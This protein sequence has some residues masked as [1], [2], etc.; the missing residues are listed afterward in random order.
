MKYNFADIE[1]KW[2]QSWEEQGV[3][4]TSENSNKPKKYILGMFPY[5]SGDGLHTGHVKL[6]TA[7]DI[8]S[9][10]YRARGYN[11]L[12]PMGWD[13]FGLPAENYA[14]KTG[15]Q[16]KITT[17]KNI[18]NF[19]GEMKRIGL[20]YDWKR[21]INTTDPEYYRWTQWI[22]LQLFHKGLAYE[23]EVAINWC[24]KDKT[25]LANEEVVNGL[26]ERC[27]TKVE[28]KVIRQWMLRITDYADRLLADLEQLEW[29]S[30]IIDMQRNWIGRSEGALITFAVDGSDLEL[31]TFTTRPDTLFGV[32]A[33][34]V[35]P[36]YDDLDKLTSSEQKES[37][38][39]YVQQ[40]S[41]IS[42]IERMNAEKPKTGVFTGSYAIHPLTGA[43]VPIWTADYVLSGY[44]T[45][46]V[47]VVPAHDERDRQFAETYELPILMVINEQ[48]QL[49]N[50][51]GYDGLT[52]DEAK[53]RIVGS[54]ANKGLAEEKVQ[55]KLRDWV[56]SRQRYWGEPIPLVHCKN[57]GVVPL[58]EEQLPLKLPEVEKYEPTG[59]GESPLAKMD[60]WVNTTCPTCNGPAKRET[61]TM[62]QWAGS[63]WYYLRF[64]DPHNKNAVISRERDSYWNP[65]D[66]YLGGAEHAVL[67]LLYAR[68]WH[69]VLFD[70]SLVERA[71]PFMKL[72]SIG[73]VLAADGKKMSKSLGN[74]I[75]PDEVIEDFGADTL[76]LYEAFMGPFENTTAWNPTGING[77]HRFLHRAWNI[78]VEQPNQPTDVEKANQELAVLADKASADIENLKLNTPIAAMMKFLNEVEAIGLSKSQKESFLIILS[79]FAPHFAEE[80]WH[81]IGN[82]DSV[83]I[84][85]WPQIATTNQQVSE[86]K[87]AVQV[88]GKVRGT[89]ESSEQA[90]EGEV[91]AMA[92]NLEAVARHLD[93]KE[94]SKVIYIPGKILNL[95]VK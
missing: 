83:V 3:Y 6:Y 37:V 59:T 47:M 87:I 5:P 8:L 53:G 56:F 91:V 66:W 79:L 70:L 1:K 34:I 11:V 29:P 36:E 46:A 63:C 27:G 92:K 42:E 38:A 72:S 93:G 64:A 62:P 31:K 32:T 94:V 41:N 89:I 54:L 81:L 40:S 78:I 39:R 13:A 68:F 12:Q 55:Y 14:I 16:P 82:S 95:V 48:G 33:V 10:Y 22:F 76:R 17:A 90:S 26:C 24:P 80:V 51:P 69:K 67:H 28:S 45:G 74:V 23:A 18:A 30:S 60:D 35:S 9:R 85:E 86:V 52:S 49:V 43:K 65:V 4:V 58:P 25:G 21:E 77:V 50:S 19:K 57:C 7:V 84:Q 75:R 88:N 71:E 2:Q 20:S 44:G 61:N 15:V 73:M